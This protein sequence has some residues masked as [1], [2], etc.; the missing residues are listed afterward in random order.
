MAWAILLVVQG[1]LP[2]A[3][4]YLTRILVD[5][6]VVAIGAGGSWASIQP[7]VIPAVL[8]AGV[9]LLTVLLQSVNEWINTAQSEL[10]QDY[11]SQKVHTQAVMVD[12]AFYE[13]P[14]Y[15]DRLHRAA[16][17]AASHPLALM[18]ST[19]SLLQNGLTLVG[20]GAVLIPY[21]LWLPVVLV[22]STLPA[23]YVVLRYNLQYHQWWEGT[24]QDRR[25]TNYYN[26]LLTNS[27]AAAEIRLFGLGDMFSDAYQSLRSR[28]RSEHLGLIRSQTISRLGASVIALLISGVAIIW[29][30]WQVIHGIYSL[31]DL[32]LFNQAFNRGQSLMR[33]LLGNIGQIYNNSLFLGNLF[34][35]FDLQPEITDPPDPVA[36]SRELRT[37]IRLSDISFRYPGSD[38][39][40]LRDFCLDIPAGQIVAIVGEN[41]AGKSTLVKLLCR[42]YDPEQGTIQFDGTDVR[43][44]AVSDLR[45]MI[46]VLFQFPVT[47]HTT[48]RKNIA[49]GDHPSD[50]EFAAVEIAAR[51]A[52]AHDV[53]ANLPLGYETL[54]GKW[55]ADGAE[56]SAGEWQKIALARAYL[57]S[58]P[59]IILDEPTSF[60]DSWS[61]ADWFERFRELAQGRTAILITHRFTIAKRADIIHVMQAGRIIESGS[62]ADLLAQGGHYAQS[63]ISQTQVQPEF[64]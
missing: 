45:R 44:I 58:A 2:V 43:R 8:F 9:M 62:H 1:L 25:W 10:I 35:F 5:G 19:G 15:F 30:G 31:G 37:G 49:I 28:L 3:S 20:M 6:L 26:T 13:S 40:V 24:T 47:Y 64:A 36:L 38:L 60:M 14:D 12:L 59:L 7:M 17:E 50:P 34:E 48:A 33:A 42:F 46:S 32:A 55:F 61:E 18:Q 29:F 41:G 57:R 21:G 51:S 27:M 22:L 54:L 23:L 39:P 16:N 52:G 63:W 53:I 4:V 56:L 11:I